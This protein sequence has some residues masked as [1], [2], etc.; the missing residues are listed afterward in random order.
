M[1]RAGMI[2]IGANLA[3]SSF[4]RDLDEVIERAVEAEIDHIIITGSDE[5]SNQRAS[6]LAQSN[7]GLLSSTAG[8]HPHHASQW[9]KAVFDQ[10]SDLI[11]QD[12]VVAIG[13]TG[14]DYNRNLSTPEQQRIAFQAHLEIAATCKKP[15]F[16]HQRDAHDDFLAMM[17]SFPDLAHRSVVHCFT[18]TE[19]ALKEYLT[20]GTMIGITGWLCDKK[21][22][23]ELRDI[24]RKIPLDRLMIESDAP[25][26]MPHREKTKKTMKEKNRNEP[27]TLGQVAQQLAD[28]R[29]ESVE[30]VI[31]ASSENACR[32][33]GLKR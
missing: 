22:G 20:L 5:S 13:E 10:I 11:R 23:K 29:E 30:T 21:R 14:L 8:L 33:F 28:C 32:L 9:S 3:S 15:L 25:Y 17:S 6:E 31:A 24:V 1:K 7:P 26:L 18:D 27:C 19:T 2:D 4:E 16:L 12:H